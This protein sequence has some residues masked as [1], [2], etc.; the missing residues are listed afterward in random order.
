M[1]T[2]KKIQYKLKKILTF[3]TLYTREIS[4]HKMTYI[5]CT[6]GYCKTNRSVILL[7]SINSVT[8]NF[9]LLFEF[10]IFYAAT[11]QRTTST[12]SKK[13]TIFK[14][15]RVIIFLCKYEVYIHTKKEKKHYLRLILIITLKST[16]NYANKHES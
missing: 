7:S 2:R 10:R 12:C 5:C 16:E 11:F 6:D 14:Y 3:A 9:L 8:S 15:A 1:L 13:T 4:I